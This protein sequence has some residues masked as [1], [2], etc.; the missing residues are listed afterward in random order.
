MKKILL[1]LV[2]FTL[3]MVTV[4]PAQEEQ[5]GYMKLDPETVLEWDRMYESLPREEYVPLDNVPDHGSKSL[6]NH[7]NYIPQ[8]RNQGACGNCWAWASTGVMAIALSVQEGIFDRLSMQYIS[9]CSFDY[10]GQPCCAGGLP[11]I[12]VEFYDYAGYCI[13]WSNKNAYYQDGD[14]SCDTPCNSIGKKPRYGIS[15]ISTQAIETMGVEKETA[16]ANIKNVLDRNKAIYLGFRLPTS[17]EWNKFYDFWGNESEAALWNPDNICGMEW[18]NGGGGHGVLLLGY[19]DDDP[20]NRYWEVVNSWGT[21][22]GRPNGMYRLDMDIDYECMLEYSGSQIPAYRFY[23]FDFDFQLATPTPTPTPIYEPGDACSVAINATRG[24]Q[25]LGAST[26]GFHNFYDPSASKNWPYSWSMSGPDFVFEINV[27]GPLYQDKIKATVSNASYDHALYII[28]DCSDS[29]GSFLI[30]TDEYN[31]N[32]GETLEYTPEAF[33]EYYLVVDSYNPLLSGTFDIVIDAADPGCPTPTP[34]PTPTMTPT[35]TPTPTPG[36]SPTPLPPFMPETYVYNF[37]G[38]PEGWEQQVNQAFD[39]PRFLEA[40]GAIGFTPNGSNNCFGAWKSPPHAFTIG[41][42]YRARFRIRTNQ[43]D[44]S[45][46]PAIRIRISDNTEQMFPS[47]MVTSKGG[48]EYAPTV[49]GMV[50]EF[51]YNA[52]GMAVSDGYHFNV[53]LINIGDA[54]DPDAEI[55]IDMLEIAKAEITVE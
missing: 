29:S 16:I 35:P 14:G 13:P 11:E 48:G 53:E 39:A 3:F 10:I 7:L 49:S 31:D 8:E 5:W 12:F 37:D 24:I 44:Q 41:Q 46:V 9:S 54:D 6:L 2:T 23:S 30:G 38:G 51:F 50:Y 20:D 43:A 28:K 27:S 1:I 18:G 21:T 45:L 42:R 25:L 40:D 52:P 55:Y 47:L 17:E 22:Q 19:N 4:L 33:T 15:F 32:T 36:P 26:E 34:S